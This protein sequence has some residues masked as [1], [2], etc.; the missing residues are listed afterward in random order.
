[1]GVSYWK[2]SSLAPPFGE[3]DLGSFLLLSTLDGNIQDLAFSV[4][5]SAIMMEVPPL[6]FMALVEPR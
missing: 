5:S 3:G 2:L 6:I 4:D 1:M